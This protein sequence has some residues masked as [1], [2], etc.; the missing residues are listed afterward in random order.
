LWT[1]VA[2]SLL[3]RSFP[4]RPFVFS[5]TMRRIGREQPEIRDFAADGCDVE[6][7]TG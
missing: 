1:I 2:A 4:I 7:R 5:A 3:Q 6:E